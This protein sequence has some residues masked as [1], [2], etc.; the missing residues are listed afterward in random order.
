[1]SAEELFEQIE[2][3]RSDAWDVPTLRS[4]HETSRV[5]NDRLHAF[6][7]A[8]EAQLAFGPEVRNVIGMANT[9]DL[10]TPLPVPCLKV[11]PTSAGSAEPKMPSVSELEALNTEPLRAQR[12]TIRYKS[13]PGREETPCVARDFL[14][15]RGDLNPHAR[16][17]TST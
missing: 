6:L 9:F 3:T 13:T 14:C 12:Y 1:M 8:P 15:A 11:R 4:F 5:S 16:S 7:G 10:A 17:D 2:T